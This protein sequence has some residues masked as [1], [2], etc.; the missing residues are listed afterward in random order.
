HSNI[1]NDPIHLNGRQQKSSIY[2]SS[3]S[4]HIGGYTSSPI[5]QLDIPTLTQIT[6]IFVQ[7]HNENQETSPVCT[8][9]NIIFQN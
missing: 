9:K 7:N 2:C 1:C 4:I 5:I 8:I 3:C 6:G